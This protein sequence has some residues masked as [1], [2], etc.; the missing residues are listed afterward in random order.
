M[1]DEYNVNTLFAHRNTQDNQVIKI[2]NSLDNPKS[3]YEVKIFVHTGANIH[4]S[5]KSFFLTK[6]SLT[7]AIVL[8]VI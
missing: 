7:F 6:S 4:Q 1:P 8:Q 5:F 3:Y 2:R